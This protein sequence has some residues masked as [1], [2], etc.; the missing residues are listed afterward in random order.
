LLA[1]LEVPA[2]STTGWNSPGYALLDALVPGTLDIIN[3]DQPENVYAA[4][5]VDNDFSKHYMVASDGGDLAK[6]TFGTT[7]TATGEFTDLGTLSGDLADNWSSLSW[8][9][10]TDTLYAA[11]STPGG[12]NMLYTI[13]PGTFESTSVGVIDGAGLNPS[14]TVIAIAISPEGLMYGIDIVDDVLLAIDKT[15]AEATVIGPLGFDANFAQD[16]DFDPSDGTLY[17][18]GYFGGGDSQMLTVDLETGAATSLGAVED[19]AEL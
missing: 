14:A 6:H 4:T 3:V 17:W 7:D 2:Y 16:M 18:A 11:G 9:H 10:Q 1:N 12:D 13:D 15:T 8:D 5:F 19:G